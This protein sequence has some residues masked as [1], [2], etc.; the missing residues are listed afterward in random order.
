MTTSTRSVDYLQGECSYRRAEEDE[1]EEEE[2]EDEIEEEEE[3]EQEE[4]QRRSS[5]CS[6]YTRKRFSLSLECVF[7]TPPCQVHNP[8]RQRGARQEGH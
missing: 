7:S 6:Q 2:D 3:D 4:V 1:E 5:A 8:R